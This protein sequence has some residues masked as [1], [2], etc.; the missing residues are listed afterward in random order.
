MPKREENIT[1]FKKATDGKGEFDF[2]REAAICHHYLNDECE[3][4]TQCK[5]LHTKGK[6]PYL[7]QYKCNDGDA[8]VS[9][10]PDESKL[11]EKEYCEPSK[12]SAVIGTASFSFE[13][14]DPTKCF[15]GTI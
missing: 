10:P 13:I 7:W 11:V 15:S 4:G 9:L 5:L 8:W 2:L 12:N 14:D 1:I 3:D 6:L